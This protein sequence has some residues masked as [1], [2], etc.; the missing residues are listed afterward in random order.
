SSAFGGLDDA[1]ALLYATLGVIGVIAWVALIVTALAHLSRT[2]RAP[3]ASHERRLGAACA[4]GILCIA[5]ACLNY[6]LVFT[7][8]SAWALVMLAALGCAAADSVPRPVRAKPRW[9]LRA[10]LPIGGTG[11]G[12]A[13]LALA[14]VTASE[15][16]SVFTVAPWVDAMQ[17]PR[18]GTEL[19]NTLC[20]SVTDPDVVAPGTSV[21][22]LD[23][24]SIYQADYPGLAVV[25]VR[26]ATP[27][28]VRQE[29]VRAFTPI[30][31]HM[32][33]EG[34]PTGTI[35]SGR[36]AW[37]TTAPLTGGALG[38]GAMLLFPPRRRRRRPPVA[39]EGG[40]EGAEG[41]AEAERVGGTVQ[42]RERVGTAQRAEGPEAVRT[43][44]PAVR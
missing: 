24:S 2:F 31:Y 1:Y 40:T 17:G 13:V 6:D 39:S 38:L 16:I 37:A 29:V 11:L 36:P 43:A 23:E 14:P 19:V 35:Q 32:P 10:L 34:G 22:C 5:A 3:T 27:G 25:T 33:M 7:S 12:V 9:A 18:G 21:T 8:E 26:A 30:Y 28:K 41:D 4:V 44:E 20:P 42:P 15:A